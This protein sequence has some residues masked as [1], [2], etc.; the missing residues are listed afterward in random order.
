MFSELIKG[1]VWSKGHISIFHYRDKAQPEVGFV[2]E[3]PAGQ[4]VGIEVK[5]AAPVTQRDFG[6]LQ[7][8]ASAAGP[9]FVQGVLLY[10]W[11]RN[12]AV[13]AASSSSPAVGFMGLI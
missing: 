1:I 10:R 11:R 9:A 7:Q 3:N 12:A 13:W 8:V 5:A 4:I 2:L 6:G